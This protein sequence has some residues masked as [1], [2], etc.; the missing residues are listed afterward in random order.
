[1]DV[2]GVA[3]EQDPAVAVLLDLAGG[4]AEPGAGEHGA[5]VHLFAVGGSQR[6]GDLVVGHRPARRAK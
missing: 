4:V 3:G 5:H 1:V 6:F 2:R